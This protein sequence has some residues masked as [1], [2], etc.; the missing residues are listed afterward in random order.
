MRGAH[1]L[2]R[3]R[4]VLEAES[5]AAGAL[6]RRARGRAAHGS[7]E[8]AV[9][10]RPAVVGVV[11]DWSASPVAETL[12][13]PPEVSKAPSRPVMASRSVTYAPSASPPYPTP[14]SVAVT[15]PEMPSAEST[16]ETLLTEAV[17]KLEPVSQRN[18]IRRGATTY[19]DAVQGSVRRSP[20]GWLPRDAALPFAIATGLV[21]L[22]LFALM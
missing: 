4:G 19:I 9:Q 22:V 12:L 11:H 21:T 5:L 1:G 10:H 15:T 17:V 20:A 13:G 8:G 6:G 3:E 18:H 7:A 16:T 2:D 14:E